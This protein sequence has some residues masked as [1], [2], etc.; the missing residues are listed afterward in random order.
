MHPHL[1]ALPDPLPRRWVLKH[2][3]GI[4]SLTINWPG[5]D[6]DNF[7]GGLEPARA[8]TTFVPRPACR[9]CRLVRQRPAP[10]LE[11]AQRFD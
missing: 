4:R 5:Y 1:P 11:S 10:L 2:A 7:I 3:S 9:L 8:P 6:Q